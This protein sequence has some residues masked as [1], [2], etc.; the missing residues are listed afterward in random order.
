M[1][2]RSGS[3]VNAAVPAT[4]PV[5]E[6]FGPGTT[7]TGATAQPS[8]SSTSA[9]NAVVSSNGITSNVAHPDAGT[10]PS[11]G[12]ETT[13]NTGSYDSINEPVQLDTPPSCD[14]T[15]TCLVPR[16][17]ASAQ[18]KQPSENMVEWA[19]DQAVHGDLTLTR[20][21]DY[22]GTGQAAF[23]P[24]SMFQPTALDGGGPY[25]LR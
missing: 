25:R 6:T 17:S 5:T 8:A 2:V 10:T 14:T 16:L 1:A 20:P 18:V 22:D 23:S 3:V 7:A 11:S 4:A 15:P 13:A 24:D 19:V 12:C 9:P 21:A